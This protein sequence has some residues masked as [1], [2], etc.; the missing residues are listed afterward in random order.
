MDVMEFF[1]QST[2]RWRSQRTT[3]HLAFKSTETGDFEIQVETLDANHPRI[4]KICE[5]HQVDPTVAIGGAF[6]QWQGEMAWDKDD[7]SNE[8]STIFV[9]IPDGGKSRQGTLLRDRG[10]A[11]EVP[12][13][14]R[15]HMDDDD[16]LVL[17]TEYDVMSATERFW[18]ASPNFRLRTSTVKR[19]G[20]FTTATFCTELRLPDG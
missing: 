6:V 20:G 9:L 7:H 19:L 11:E 15:Y 10:Y 18:F 13:A 8:G 2:G 4:L 12:V 16:G 5:L 3:H 14:G 1:Q 17:T